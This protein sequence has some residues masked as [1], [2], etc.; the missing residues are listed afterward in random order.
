MGE[1]LGGWPTLPGG[2][3]PPPG[4]PEAREGAAAPARSQWQLF[5]RQFVR[6]RLAMASVA[7]LAVI[8]L[9]ALLAEQV[10][11]Y[12]FEEVNLAN[13]GT[14][15]TFDDSHFF[16]TDQIGRDYFSRTLYGTRTSVAVALLVA[17][18]ST[19]IGTVVGALA[20]YYRGWVDTV[21]MRAVDFLLA[22]PFL[23]VVLIAAAFLGRGSPLRIGLILAL[24]LWTTIARIVRGSFLSLR[25]REFVEAARA[26]GASDTRII[27]RHMLPNALGPIV[28]NATLTVALAILLEAGLSFLGFGVQRPFPAL[29]QM[30]ADGRGQMRTQWW[31]VV[32]P[33]ATIV[34]ICLCIN[35]IGDGLRD[36][37]DPTQQRRR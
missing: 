12:G 31:L 18:A 6:H 19:A 26:S 17:S 13:R 8:T 27:F 16:G 10:A 24:L 34:V 37:L 11:P 36:A 30:I 15:P 2:D 14:P 9:T 25:E 1:R 29:G 4:D 20:G 28:V 3:V 35:F 7:V 32:M 21:A 22:V 5:R 23:A 33:G